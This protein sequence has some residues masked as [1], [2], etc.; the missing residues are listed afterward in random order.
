MKNNEVRPVENGPDPQSTDAVTAVQY[1]FYDRVVELLDADGSLANSKD[2]DGVTLLHW[3]ALNNRIEIAK[4]LHK[5]GA[6]VDAIGGVLH[7]TPLFWAIREGKVEMVLLLL[8]LGAQPSFVDADGQSTDDLF[9][10]EFFP[11][12]F[13]SIHLACIFGHTPIVAYLVA[14]GQDVNQPDRSGVTPLMHAAF[15]VR[16]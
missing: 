13:S 6:E 10:Y 7:S 15:H 8:S 4:L 5:R 3:A 11:S 14:R 12:G 16:E 9:R 1:G 2:K